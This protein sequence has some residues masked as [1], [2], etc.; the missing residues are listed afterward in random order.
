[1]SKL[2]LGVG[3]VVRN[4]DL[5]TVSHI[6]AALALAGGDISKLATL[7]RVAAY[8]ARYGQSHRVRIDASKAKLKIARQGGQTLIEMADLGHRDAGHGG[9]RRSP[10][11][12][13]TVKLGDL[14]LTRNRSS[15]WQAIAKMPEDD[16]EARLFAIEHEEEDDS[17]AVQVLGGLK[18][19]GI[20]EWYTPTHY[21]EAAREVMGGID[22]DPASSEL[23]NRTVRA[24]RI[25]TMAD[26]GLS[27]PWEGRIWLN[28]P[29]GKGSG[30]FTT[31]L[32]EEYETGHVEAAV[33]LLNAYGFDAMWF[34]PLWDHPICFTDHR[35]TF[36]SPQRESGGPANGN[37][38]IYLGTDEGA[39]AERFRAFGRIVR[40]LP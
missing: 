37:I 26:D 1:M 15:R 9:D 10:S 2:S 27:Q 32:V 20:V 28:P 34:Q 23:A 7:D 36:T 5:A 35:I 13:G 19:S 30:L 6:D 14:G 4:G 25:Y 16:Y 31:K 11:R 39:F 24:D 3:R 17:L 21:I 8:V 12:D 22:L 29:Y 40:A 18:A 33:L 38:F